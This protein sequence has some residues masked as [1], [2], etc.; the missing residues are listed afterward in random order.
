MSTAINDFMAR[1]ATWSAASNSALSEPPATA[2]AA[3]RVTFDHRRNLIVGRN[4]TGKPP[5][6]YE[7]NSSRTVAQNL[8]RGLQQEMKLIGQVRERFGKAM[9]LTGPKTVPAIFEQD[10]SHLTDEITQLNAQQE[11]LRDVQ[12]REQEVLVSL[13]LQVK[14]AQ[15]ALKTYE[16]DASFLRAEPHETLVCPTCGAEHQKTFMDMLTYAEDARVLRELMVRLQGDAHKAAEAYGKTRERLRELDQHYNR[17]SQILE[18]RRGD[19]KFDDVVKSLGAEVAF[20]AF[21]DEVEALKSQID[22]RLSE[23]ES[24][25]AKLSEL[26]SR[27]RSNQILTL[28]RDSYAAARHALNLPPIDTKNLRLTSRPDVSGSG[29]PRSILAYYSALWRASLGEHGSFSVPL[30]IDSPQQQG[31]DEVNLPKMIEYVAKYLPEGSQ[32][33]LGI[34]AITAEEFDHVI[35]LNDPYQL[36]REEEY[37]E[38]N[39]LVEPYLNQMYAS[40]FGPLKA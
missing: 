15:E 25:E 38:V 24:L 37:E 27:E 35:E 16:S 23:I 20:E 10:I 33:L 1:F 31:Q 30:V 11:E 39:A 3:S 40:L 14:M 28:F 17:V 4:H 5:E 2:P 7:I 8:L 32:V 22:A 6:Y 34:E 18:T 36:L 26:T 9:P 13:R 21:E 12:V 19:L 29:G